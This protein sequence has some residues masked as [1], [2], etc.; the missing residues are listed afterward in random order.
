MNEQAKQELVKWCAKRG[1]DFMEAYR[2]HIK[3]RLHQLREDKNYGLKIFSSC[4]RL[5]R[6]YASQYF[7][8]VSIISN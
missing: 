5:N 3:K 4:L 7:N 2:S 1:D 6:V 8:I